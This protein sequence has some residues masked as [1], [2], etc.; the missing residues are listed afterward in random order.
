MVPLTIEKVAKL[1]A[2]DTSLFCAECT[3]FIT[4]H[5][6]NYRDLDS[7]E[8]QSCILEN[9][10]EIQHERLEYSGSHRKQK[11]NQG[12]NENYEL[13]LKSPNDLSVLKP[14]YYRPNHIIRFGDR[15]VFSESEDFEYNIFQLIRAFVLN[16]FIKKTQ[17]TKLF[18]FGCGPAHNLV[19][20]AHRSPNIQ[21]FGL[22]W[23]NSS[24]RIITQINKTFGYSIIGKKYDFFQPNTH[25][26]IDDNSVIVTFGALEQTSSKWHDLLTYWLKSKP[27]LIINVEPI[28]E[29]YH[30][31]SLID[32]LGL[33]YH[34][35]RNYLAGYYTFLK[36]L[37]SSGTIKSLEVHKVAIGGRYMNGWNIL[38][39]KP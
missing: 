15:Y 2:I 14:R 22:D 35:K 8:L 11:W 4:N 38:V 37:L 28:S 18:E 7:A 12:W 19:Y 16:N 32:Y 31:K 25:L 21:Y 36:S 26:P 24:Q 33:M 5:N 1:L 6:F 29:L 34:Q 27:A 20:F 13:L 39:W 23:A 10:Q 30:Q 9:L 3:E 17:H